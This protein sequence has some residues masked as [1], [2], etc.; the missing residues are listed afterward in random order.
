[1][2]GGDEYVCA[3][4]VG[5]ILVTIILVV[6]SCVASLAPNE[7]GM[8]KNIFSGRVGYEVHRG[9]IHLVGPMK[10]FVRFPATQVTV[11]FSQRSQPNL[12]INTRT[13]ADPK[14][15][16]SG[17][18][19]I[20]IS[21]AFQFILAQ[22]TIRKLY[23]N[24]GGY[25]GALARI[26][27]VSGNAVSNT[28]Q[29]FIPKDFWQ[30]RDV[31]A[32]RMLD[33][34]N[35]TLWDQVFVEVVRFEIMKV[36]FAMRFEESITGVQ[37]AEQA[38]VINEYQQQVAKVE[39]SIEVM[40]SNNDAVIANISGAASA[41][42]KELRAV[43][44]R[45]AFNLKQTKKA[46]MYAALKGALEFTEPQMVEYFKIKALQAQATKGKMVVGLPHVGE[47]GPVKHEL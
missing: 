23:L 34:M 3:A 22:E 10:T 44:Q 35:K 7:F 45:D 4:G 12:P 38:K 19:P 40:S 43:A 27:L 2:T 36:D 9:G 42:A 13:G 37:V 47:P 25:E 15:P 46:E 29:E 5:C 14:D 24:F 26:K 32:A 17:G 1:L 41:R 39:Q 33:V 30:R 18:Q 21:C 31:V 16:D 28:A 8:T 6:V 20:K 11:Q